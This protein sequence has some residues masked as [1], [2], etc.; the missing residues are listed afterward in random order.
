MSAL[1][2]KQTCAAHTLTSALGQKRTFGFY[3]QGAQPKSKR[4]QLTT[5]ANATAPRDWIDLS[6]V[7]VAS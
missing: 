3:H 2:Q 1:G 6:Q 7:E 4:L 5:L